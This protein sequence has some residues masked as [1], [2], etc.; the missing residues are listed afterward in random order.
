MHVPAFHQAEHF[1][2]HAA[3]LQRFAIELAGERIERLHDVGDGTITVLGG[4]RSGSF[5]GLIEH[6]RIRFLHH[7]FAE[8]DAD[9]VVLEDVVIEHVLGGFAQIEDPLAQRR[10]FH[11]EGHVLRVDGASSVVVATDAANSTCNKV[12]V[13][14]IFALHKDAIPAK[15]GRSA[16]T[17]GHLPII[18]I[19]LGENAQASYDSSN[20]SQFISTKFRRLAAALR[21][22]L[23]RRGHFFFFLSALSTLAAGSRW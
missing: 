21:S 3:H 2:R 6:A 10:R 13:P 19:D 16:V 12:G 18:E 20:G 7:L 17:L 1:A 9:Q 22:G 14:R 4:I 11:A 5:L 23:N 15:D 8:I